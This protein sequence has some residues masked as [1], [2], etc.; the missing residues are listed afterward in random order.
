MSYKYK[1][2]GTYKDREG[3]LRYY[4]FTPIGDRMNTT[5]KIGWEELGSDITYGYL[6]NI[7][8]N[9]IEE[10]TNTIQL[11][12]ERRKRELNGTQQEFLNNVKNEEGK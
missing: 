4:C 11:G 9:S 10:I 2:S 12:W 7:E 8:F 6:D 1:F 3:G 5:I